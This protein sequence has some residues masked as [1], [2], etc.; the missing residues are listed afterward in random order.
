MC[1]IRSFGVLER[2]LPLFLECLDLAGKMR[3]LLFHTKCLETPANTHQFSSV[4]LMHTL[5]TV[6]LGS[7]VSALDADISQYSV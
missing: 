6:L 1:S 4:S 2:D 5:K 3:F 7:S